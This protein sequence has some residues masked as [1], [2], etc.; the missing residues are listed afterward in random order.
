MF[1]IKGYPEGFDV[2]QPTSEELEYE[3]AASS[4]D[5]ELEPP[6]YREPEEHGGEDVHKPLR[7]E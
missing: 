2:F 1:C 5:L 3:W 7:A 6:P 4:P